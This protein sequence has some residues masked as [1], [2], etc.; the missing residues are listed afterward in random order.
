[1][2]YIN[3]PN[4]ADSEVNM[5]LFTRFSGA[6]IAVMLSSNRKNEKANGN[7]IFIVNIVQLS[8]HAYSR[9]LV[10]NGAYSLLSVEHREFIVWQNNIF[11]DSAS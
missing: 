8:A 2:V 7:M 6:Y 3:L 10:W 5:M 9:A 4:C 11:L 1:V